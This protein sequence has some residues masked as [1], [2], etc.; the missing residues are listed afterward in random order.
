MVFK[1]FN[2]VYTMKA[3][4]YI[5]KITGIPNQFIDDLFSFYD[6]NTLQTDFVINIKLVAKWLEVRRETLMDTLQRSYKKGIDYII[7][8]TENPQKKD[9]RSNNHKTVLVT[10]DCFK[11][12][13]MLTRSKKGETVRTYFIEIENTFIKYRQQTLEGIK[14]DMKRKK[15]KPNTGYIYVILVR[16]N[17]HKI[18][19]SQDM[20]KRM[21]TYI[22]GRGRDMDVVYLYQT[23]DLKEVEGCMKSWLRGTRYQNN[24]EIFEVDIDTLK[25]LINECGN[26]GAKL[27]LKNKMR[28]SDLKD[29]G[30]YYVVLKKSDV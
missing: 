21:S 23:E 10:P 27:H 11:R 16:D 19:Y 24:G 4:H 26:I 2:K 15:Y 25:K 30:A 22:T 14:L 9:P 17:L 13:C 7:M 3:I 29:G 6:E 1:Y 20:N 5:K 12:L 18:G 8:K 28:D